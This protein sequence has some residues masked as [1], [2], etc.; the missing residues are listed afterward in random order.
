LDQLF[1]LE[2][3]THDMVFDSS[4]CF[5]VGRYFGRF[6]RISLCL[7]EIAQFSEM[8]S[9]QSEQRLDLRNF[10]VTF[11]VGGHV[12]ANVLDGI[13]LAAD[14]ESLGLDIKVHTK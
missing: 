13:Q 9:D 4:V 2:A 5:Y 6:E 14:G 11:K 12:P 10:F 8:F 7:L 1:D 3:S